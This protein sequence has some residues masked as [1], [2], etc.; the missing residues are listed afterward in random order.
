MKNIIFAAE[1][2]KPR[3]VLRDAIDNVIEMVEGADR[4]LVYDSPLSRNGL[5]RGELVEWW[6]ASSPASGRTS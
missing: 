3:I 2:N 6:A 4:V 5:T 1:G